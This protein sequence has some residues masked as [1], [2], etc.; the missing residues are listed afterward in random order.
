MADQTQELQAALS[1]AEA[2]RDALAAR[3]EFARHHMLAVE[4]SPLAIMCVSAI[5]GRY[6][7]V[8]DEYAR[9]VGYP[10]A[11]LL[12]RDPYEL[13]LE[14][15]HP[16]EA[17]VERALIG[18]VGKGEI[19]RFQLD[20][21]VLSKDGSTH[22]V[23]TELR[24]SRDAQGRLEYIVVSFENLGPLRAA[25][26]AREQLEA[27]LRRPAQGAVGD[28]RDVLAEQRLPHRGHGATGRR[29]PAGTR[30]NVR[31]CYPYTGT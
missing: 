16:D 15:T 23:H 20:K 9:L 19:D 7:F 12:E 25:D 26:A 1:R 17:E 2:E 27:Q 3:L 28:V 14:V 4:Q 13:W 11:E 31:R 29:S 6:V 30:N 5:K 22:W 18:R 8:N 10:R 21:R 24:S